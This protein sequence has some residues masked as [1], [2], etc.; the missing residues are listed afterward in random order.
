MSNT[1]FAFLKSAAVPDRA[2]LQA[3][4]DD[5]GFDL[6]LHPEINLKSDQGFSPCVLEGVE[7]VGFELWPSATQELAEDNEGVSEIAGD[8]DFCI[9]MSWRGSM[10]DC[11]A[12]MI[13]SCALAKNCDAVISYEGDQPEPLAKMLEATAEILADARGET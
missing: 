10:K 2:A 12:V 1:Q 9:S 7:D 5:L 11:A 6:K 13:V 3:W 4:I 8:R